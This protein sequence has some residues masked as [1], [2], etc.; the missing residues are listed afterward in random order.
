MDW[1][2]IGLKEIEHIVTEALAKATPEEK[3]LFARTAVPP[4]KWQLSPWGDEGG[5]FWVVA[6]MDDRVLWFND[7]EDGFNVSRFAVVGR[8]PSTEYWC[9]QDEL[10]LAIR[11][12]A[13][14]SR[15]KFG[16]PQPF[17]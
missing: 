15:G 17:T 9:N 6:V 2:S 11:A 3:A 12:L 1:D 13:G 10:P 7:I 8:I 16:P 4:T 5:G 14:E